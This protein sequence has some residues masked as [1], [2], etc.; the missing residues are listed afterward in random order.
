M[1][2]PMADR[3]RKR[4]RHAGAS[5]SPA[6]APSRPAPTRPSPPPAPAPGGGDAMKRGYAKAEQKNVAARAALQPIGPENRPR[7]VLIACAWLLVACVS[8][9]VSIVT[10]DGDGVGGQRFGNALMLLVVLVAVWGTYRLRP[11]AILGSQTL[12]ALA[13]VFTILAAVFS[14]K[15]LLSLALAASALVTGWIFY[16]MINVMA[17]VQKM[18]LQRRGELDESRPQG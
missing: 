2:G 5:A 9:V 6:G 3:K 13:F 16:R 7:I 4:K 8:I 17:R 18:E 12:F 14:D 10:A 1:M 11:W 15:P